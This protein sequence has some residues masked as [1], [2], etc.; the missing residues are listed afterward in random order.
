MMFLQVRP[1]VHKILVV[2]E[3]LLIDEDY[4]ARVEGPGSQKFQGTLAR[5]VNWDANK[6]QGSKQKPNNGGQGEKLS[7]IWRR[8]QVFD[9]AFEMG[10]AFGTL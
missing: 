7:A 10:S 5:M 1:Y 4:F 6:N 3:P 9:L 8:R 2:I